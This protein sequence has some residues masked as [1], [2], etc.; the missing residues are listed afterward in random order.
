MPGK[1][2][3]SLSWK[4]RSLPGLDKTS[5]ADID[6]HIFATAL[7]AHHP[8]G[9]CKMGPATDASAVVGPDLRVHGLDALR[10]V[11]ASVMP[12]LVG[13]MINAPV[14][15]IA[16][17]GADLVRGAGHAAGVAKLSFVPRALAIDGSSV[18]TM[19]A[20]PRLNCGV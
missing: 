5:D 18:E 2:R 7:T 8:L 14:V 1:P 6:A 3:S 10:V 9:T 16:E 12:D 15:M 20:F 13:G 19:R 11:D 17:R 4:R